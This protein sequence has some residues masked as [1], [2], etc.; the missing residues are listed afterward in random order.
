VSIRT[1]MRGFLVLFAV[2]AT[3]MAGATLLGTPAAKAARC[4][5]VMVCS[6]TPP[7][8]CWEVCKTCPKFP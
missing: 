3:V 6:N 4:C 7:Y 2:A 5:W 8:A 1:P